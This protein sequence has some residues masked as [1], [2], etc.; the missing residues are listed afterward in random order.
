MPGRHEEMTLS[1]QILH[2]KVAEIKHVREQEQG[3]WEKEKISL[4]KKYL[5]EKND[6]VSFVFISFLFV[7]VVYII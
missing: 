2:D 6:A 7:P 1:F 5:R 4:K 3:R